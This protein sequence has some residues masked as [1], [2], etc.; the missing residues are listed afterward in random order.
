MSLYPF[1]V[2]P[3]GREVADGAAQTVRDLLSRLVHVLVRDETARN[4]EAETSAQLYHQSKLPMSN[5][6]SEKLNLPVFS[7]VRSYS[8]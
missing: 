3:V 5:V 1:V 7:T 6:T 8:R 2:V 4:R